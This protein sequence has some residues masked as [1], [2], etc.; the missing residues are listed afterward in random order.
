MRAQSANFWQGSYSTG[1]RQTGASA[2]KGGSVRVERTVRLN[3]HPKSRAFE[4]VDRPGS[5]RRLG[6][7]QEAV[8]RRFPRPRPAH[9][10]PH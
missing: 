2:L 5:V 4:R 7:E 6:E 1:W 10:P 8:E 3:F 9:P